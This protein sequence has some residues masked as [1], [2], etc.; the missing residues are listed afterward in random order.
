MPPQ[1]PLRRGLL[2]VVGLTERPRTR[3]TFLAGVQTR[4]A[5]LRCLDRA[6]AR[7]R[8]RYFRFDA[9]I[10][11]DSVLVMDVTR[12]AQSSRSFASS[13]VSAEIQVC[14]QRI[15]LSSRLQASHNKAP[16]GDDVRT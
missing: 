5:D 10:P 4:Q 6:L 7:S 13:A 9:L 14:A 16:L 8:R 15:S 3:A 11:I 2:F 1:A 12:P